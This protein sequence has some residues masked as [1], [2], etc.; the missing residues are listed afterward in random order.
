MVKAVSN[1]VTVRF[2]NELE[3]NITIKLG[4]RKLL[5]PN[6]C[7]S[8]LLFRNMISVFIYA[9]LFCLQDPN[10]RTVAALSATLIVQT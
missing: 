1:V 3:R 8:G 9:Y 4:K 2:K 5:S 7:W 10:L 6:I